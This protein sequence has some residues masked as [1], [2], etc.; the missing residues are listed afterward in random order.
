MSSARPLP[1]LPLP[2]AAKAVT[3]GT[4][5]AVACP[6]HH[7][8]DQ[9]RRQDHLRQISSTSK[10]EPALLLGSSR[11]AAERRDSLDSLRDKAGA[12]RSLFFCSGLVSR[13]ALYQF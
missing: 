6:N 13:R 7:H 4:V 12:D 10:S 1:P 2:T 9:D 11:A 5:A 3:A 8:Q